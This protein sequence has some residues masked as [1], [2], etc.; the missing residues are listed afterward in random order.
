MKHQ[1]GIAAILMG[2]VIF[3]G[4]IFIQV[5]FRSLNLPIFGILVIVTGFGCGFITQKATVMKKATLLF[6]IF[7]FVIM[8]GILIWSQSLPETTPVREPGPEEEGPPRGWIPLISPRGVAVLGAIL[9]GI[10]IVFITP[11]V[12][13]SGLVGVETSHYLFKKKGDE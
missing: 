6:M 5:V 1:S 3:C 2:I 9:Y 10:I 11:V 4:Y 12:W 7:G 8:G 13:I